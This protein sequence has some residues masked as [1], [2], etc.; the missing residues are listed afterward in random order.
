MTELTGRA[1]LLIANLKLTLAASPWWYVLI[2]LVLAGIAY[3]VYRYTLPP[4]GSGRRTLL[5]LLRG[6]ALVLLALLLF[7]PV[8]SY[9]FSRRERPAVALL[10]DRSASINGG[11]SGDRGEIVRKWL[12]SSATQRLEDKSSLHLFAFADSTDALPAD[13]LNGLSFS[14]VGTDIAGAIAEAEKS[15]AAENL[16]AIVVVSDGAYN[17]GENPVRL[18]TESTAPIYAIGVG[19]T[20]ARRDAVISQMLTNEI[21]YVGSTVPVELRIRGRGLRDQQTTVRLMGPQGR[22]YGRQSVRFSEEDS[23]LSLS[24]ELTA[25][26]AGDLRV[27][28]VLDSVV[29]ETMVENNR[30]SVIIRVLENKSRIVLFS[31]PPSPDL[32]ILRQALEADS[33]LETKLFV[34]A[35]SGQLLYNESVPVEEDFTRADLIILQ[36]YP[37]RNSSD[38]II[39][40]IARTLTERDVPVL[41]FAGPQTSASKLKTVTAALPFDQAKQSL[42]EERVLLRA[43]VA[44][45]AISGAS[46]LAKEWSDLPPTVG[47]LDNFDVKPGAQVAVKLSRESLGLTEDEPA[48]AFWQVGRKHGAAFFCWGL[49]RWRLQK[50]SVAGDSFYDQLISRLVAWLIAPAEEQRVKIRTTKRMYSGGEKVQF[51]GQVYGSDLAPRDDA[52]INLRV[53]SGTRSEVVAM[54]NRGNGRYEGEFAPWAEGDYNYIV[55]ASV[56]RDSLGMD[57]GLFAVEAFNIELIDTR[58]RFDVMQAMATASHGHFVPL[59]KADSLFSALQFTPRAITTRRE[60]PLW[61]RALMVWIIIGLLA[62][63]W[64]IRKRSGML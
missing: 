45:P 23:E 55:S 39:E 64:I 53:T 50:V 25:E 62:A 19:D 41:F 10:V 32:T 59:E 63:E 37:S 26:R 35:A 2:A 44:H 11:S 47:G 21:T 46:P 1:P 51:I 18:A 38:A 61:N 49:Y 60:F 22:E 7:E 20:T 8:L 29:G 54:R 57:R 16:A 31:G 27:E 56:E 9:M 42:T 24:M 58:A 5:W 36:N 30:R 33:T 52:T 34:E 3:A 6:L 48:V 13:S 4:V 28:A 14:G 12:T 43:A 17:S 40:R 15:L